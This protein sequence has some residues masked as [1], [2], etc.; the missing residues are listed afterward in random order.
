MAVPLQYQSQFVPTNFNQVNNVLGMYK[1]DMQGREQQFDQGVAMQD[2]TLAQMAEQQTSDPAKQKELIDS[3]RSRIGDAVQAKGMDYGAA[4]QD[5]SGLISK[6]KSNP[7]YGFDKAK[8]AKLQEEA[9]LKQQYGINY[10]SSKNARDIGLEDY[11]ADPAVFDYQASNLTDVKKEMSDR[12][13]AEAKLQTENILRRPTAGV[14]EIGKAIGYR[15]PESRTAF[16]QGEGQKIIDEI[17]QTYG[18]DDPQIRAQLEQEMYQNI[19]GREDVT[20]MKDPNY[21][22]TT[23]KQPSWLSGINMPQV[24]IEDSRLEETNKPVL[25]V[26]KE[27]K[28]LAESIDKPITEDIDVA[29]YD[30][31]LVTNLQ[32]KYNV[33]D[34]QLESVMKNY[35]ALNKS[36]ALNV[37]LGQRRI[38]E[39][40]LSKKI[41]KEM[42]RDRRDK[43]LLDAKEKYSNYYTE[44]MSDKDFLTNVSEELKNRAKKTD[45][46]F[47][48]NVKGYNDIARI[49][50][51]SEGQFKRKGSN[52]ELSLNEIYDQYKEAGA[53][54][55]YS[56]SSPMFD[57]NLNIVIQGY[58]NELYEMKPSEGVH[59]YYADRLKGLKG[60]EEDTNLT[61]QEIEQ[62]KNMKIPLIGINAQISFDFKKENNKSLQKMVNIS[63]ADT[64]SELGYTTVQMPLNQFIN[65][66][67]KNMAQDAIFAQQLTPNE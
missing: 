10:Y 13:I 51:R 54:E 19:G 63:Y 20:R 60:L 42:V 43:D 22:T 65:K 46:L 6:E 1:Q 29:T 12:A 59:K 30:P 25:K 34:T 24:G 67:Y 17:M 57:D 21:T 50:L 3:L 47:S 28:S 5:I 52:K 33:K 66:T 9:K 32:Q 23:S 14:L 64:N 41:T 2:M 27:L 4:A 45:K 36:E 11:L 40:E 31:A 16:V 44:G 56:Q 18:Y 39:P 53:T 61:E 8:L 26:S 37:L 7:F 49:N 55:L 62:Y 15:T 35:P 38:Y 48:M 58:D